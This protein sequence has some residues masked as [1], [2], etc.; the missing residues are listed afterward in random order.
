MHFYIFTLKTIQKIM[1]KGITI[2]ALLMI[3]MVSQIKSQDTFSMVAVDPETREVGSTGASCVDMQYFPGYTAD[4]LSELFPGLGGIN[5]QAWYLAT[6]QVNARNRMLAGD[7]PSEIIE[8]LIANDAQNQPQKRQYGIVAFVDDEPESAAFTGTQTDDYKNHITGPNYSIQGNILRGQEVLDSM[9]VRFQNAEGDLAC[10]LM[11]ALQGAKMVGA[12]KRCLA[13]GTSALFAFVKVAQPDDNFGDPSF[14][15]TVTTPENEG[16]EPIDSLQVLFD[17][18]HYCPTT[19]VN[20]NK[21]FSEYFSIFPN[22]TNSKVLLSNN[23]KLSAGEYTLAIM[24][25]AGNI[26]FQTRYENNIE[27]EVSSFAKGIYFIRITNERDS[28]I[29]KFVKN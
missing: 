16:I 3:L 28:Y 10:R 25:I 27:L 17:A 14:V 19:S 18:V 24:D 26:L 9:E 21:L 29:S 8:W 15:L 11:A 13:N 22:P 6:N 5:T 1:N 7:T 12:D 2:A 23:N 20:D 4:F